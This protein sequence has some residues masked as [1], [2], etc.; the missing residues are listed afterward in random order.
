MSPARID[1]NGS[2]VRHSGWLGSELP[3]AVDGKGDLEVDRLLAPQRAVVVEHRNALLD[4]YVVGTA[5]GGRAH[6]TAQSYCQYPGVH[7]HEP[8]CNA[9]FPLVH[10]DVG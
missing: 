5:G 1:L 6:D 7:P 2:C 3:Y 4:G 8:S 9:Q 10:T